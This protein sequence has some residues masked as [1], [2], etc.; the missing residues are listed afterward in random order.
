MFPLTQLD[1]LYALRLGNKPTS[2]GFPFT[3]GGL[4]AY[5][6][7]I[8]IFTHLIDVGTTLR[9]RQRNLIIGRSLDK[10]LFSFTLSTSEGTAEFAV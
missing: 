3:E 9:F 5:F 2:L 7:F 6:R 8:L 1:V 4:I 10:G